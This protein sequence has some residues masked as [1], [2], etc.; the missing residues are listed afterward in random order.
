MLI[1]LL[2]VIGGLAILCAYLR[3]Y[4]VR[5]LFSVLMVVFWIGFFVLLGFAIG[6]QAGVLGIH[7]PHLRI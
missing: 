1:L 7:P 2:V 4:G 3:K 6:Y 5:W